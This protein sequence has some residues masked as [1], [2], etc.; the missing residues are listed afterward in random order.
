M[1][2]GFVVLL[3]SLARV[4]DLTKCL[5]LNDEL[6]MVRSTIIDMN[7]VE[8]NYYL[9][10]ISLNKCTGSCN[11]LSPKIIVPKE[12]KDINVKAFNMTANKDEAKAITEHISCDCKCKFNS[13]SC[14]SNQKWNNKTCQC[15]CKTYQKC[16]K[17]Y[18]WNP[19][20]CICEKSKNLKK[21]ADTTVT[22]CDEIIIVMDNLSTKKTNTIA[23]NVTSTASIN[24]TVKK[25]GIAIFCI[26]FY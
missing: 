22:Q 12:T 19:S 15:E 10:I 14:N 1:I 8:L 4:A 23:T 18:S 2:F 16:E 25:E 13:T 6:C 24:C 3:S 11:V 21:V 5:F 26:Q 17:D 9:F 20:T 7:P